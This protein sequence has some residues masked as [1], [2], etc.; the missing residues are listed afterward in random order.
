MN[1]KIQL[2][3]T[4]ILLTRMHQSETETDKKAQTIYSNTMKQMCRLHNIT[5]NQ[6]EQAMSIVLRMNNH[7]PTIKMTKVAA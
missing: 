3:V 1:N 5:V 6:I 7:K 2:C 4:M